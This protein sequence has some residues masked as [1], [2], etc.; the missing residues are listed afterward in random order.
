MAEVTQI[1]ENPDDG[2][3][4]GNIVVVTTDENGVQKSG[5]SSWDPWTSKAEAT[6]RATQKALDKS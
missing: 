6:E 5:T 2:G 3:H 1:I 4:Y